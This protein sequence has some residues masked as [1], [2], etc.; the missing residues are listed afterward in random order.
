STVRR[1]SRDHADDSSRVCRPHQTIDWNSD[2][3]TSERLGPAQSS[4]GPDWVALPV[5]EGNHAIHNYRV[6]AN[7]I[8]KRS[9]ERRTVS[10]SCGIEYDYIRSHPGSK[11]PAITEAKAGSRKRC[12]FSNRLT[13]CHDL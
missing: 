10:D 4:S 6:N 2:C 3:A 9:I 11:T 7:R 12:H 8:L 1:S 5:A 13:E